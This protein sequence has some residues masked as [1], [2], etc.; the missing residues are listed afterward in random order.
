MSRRGAVPVIMYHRVGPEINDWS[1]S[2]G[3]TISPDTFED[4]L[5]WLEKTGYYTASLEELRAHI[6]GDARLP[7]RSVVLTFDDGYIDNW[8][9][10][11]PMLARHGFKASIAIIP[12]F[13]DPRDIVRPTMEDVWA[14]RVTERDLEVRAF[15]SWPELRAATDRGVLS[16]IAHSLT[17]TWFPT[18]SRI[19]DFHRPGDGHFWLDWNEA[20]ASK[21]FYLQRPNESAVPWGTPVY[22][23][24]RALESTR[25]FP[26]PREAAHLTEFV[27]SNGAEAFFTKPGWL[28]RL[29]EVARKSREALPLDD[30]FE[31]EAER[32]DRY[33]RDLLD[34]KN[35]IEGKLRCEV[36]HFIWP[37][38]VFSSEAMKVARGIFDSVDSSHHRT[39]N[40]SFNQPGGDPAL[41]RRFGVPD[42]EQPG[43]IYYPGGR[44]LVGCL[45]EFRGV[46]LARKFRQ[47]MK[48][49]LLAAIKLGTTAKHT[50]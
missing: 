43:C 28:D 23:H 11:V 3:L 34:A 39:R 17:H 40:G 5:V 21:P 48:L 33:H 42:I 38:Q 22:E 32:S 20:P 36:R 24:A 2:S 50:R 4:H 27:A 7:E 29:N 18:G 37:G 8:T 45:D 14:S 10:V 47:A 31:T 44:Y 35:I 49:G 19:V 30:R 6:K 25:Y 26:D 1:W 46:S 16:V 41:F 15:V 12:D 9:H 13:V